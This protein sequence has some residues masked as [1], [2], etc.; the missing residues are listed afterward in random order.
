MITLDRGHLAATHEAAVELD[1]DLRAWVED[2]SSD[3][4]TGSV[5]ELVQLLRAQ[6]DYW[7]RVQTGRLQSV[8]RLLARVARPFFTPQIRYNLLL[9]DLVGRIEV[10]LAEIRRDIQTKQDADEI[11][12]PVRR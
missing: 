5:A 12:I 3:L 1:E 8:R 10:S 11:G 7:E 2:T 9:A 6:G 4:S